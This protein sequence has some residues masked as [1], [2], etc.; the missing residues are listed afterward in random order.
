MVMK[1]GI[2]VFLALIP[3]GASGGVYTCVDG[4]KVT[5]S[6]QACRQAARADTGS[7]V[8][9]TPRADA[10]T[11]A[12]AGTGLSNPGKRA[13]RE[14][15]ERRLRDADEELM[16]LYRERRAAVEE[17]MARL[18]AEAGGAGLSAEE[19]AEERKAFE[20]GYE[21]S[22]KVLRREIVT[23]SRQLADPDARSGR[24]SYASR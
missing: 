20:A 21:Q 15:L 16:W 18:L 8:R 9:P 7:T 24:A 12:P 19:R 1:A 3:L 17:H 6:D 14:A 5:Y 23:L 2:A 4:D 10:S 22:I 11:L 13:P